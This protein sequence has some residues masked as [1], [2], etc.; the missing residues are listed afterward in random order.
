MTEIALPKLALRDLTKEF[1]TPG[2]AGRTV[3]VAGISLD[4]RTGEFVCIVGPSGCGKS[5]V[6][7]MIAGLEVPS[8]GS[9]E[10]DGVPV[11]GPSAE[12]G[13]MF[14]DYALFPWRNV[15]DNVGFGLHYGTPGKGMTAAQRET[16]TRHFINLVALKGAERKYPHQLSGGMRQRVALA[17]LLANEPDI[18]LMD[19]PLGALDA[20]TRL[21]L[22]VELLRIWG[23]TNPPEQRK[24]AVF[25][26]HA[27][28]EAVFLGDRVV[29]MGS[30]PGRIKS[31]ISIDLP[32]PR[33]EALRANPRFGELVD[34]IWNL[35]REEAYQ[36]IGGPAG[37]DGAGA[38]AVAAS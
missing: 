18:L 12:R 3:A 17:R 19:E 26:T 37:N 32:R 25:I 1:A 8:G 36:A 22:Q 9:I 31:I 4:V 28:D 38:A 7:N 27:I 6:L 23:E 14:Q 11:T 13:V 10:K 29:V 21:I 16:R 20:Q 30:N 33:T 35:I 2:A 15:H 34:A 24:T 5:T